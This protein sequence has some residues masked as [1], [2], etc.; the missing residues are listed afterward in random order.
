MAKHNGNANAGACDPIV[1][2]A[3]KRLT[4]LYSHPLLHY[5]ATLHYALVHRTLEPRDM[6][7][8]SRNTNTMARIVEQGRAKGARPLSL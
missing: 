4:S 5:H 3:A 1:L 2:E 7:A 6:V 8:A